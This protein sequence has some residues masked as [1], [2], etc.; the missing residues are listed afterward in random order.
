MK[1]EIYGVKHNDELVYVG[2]TQYGMPKRRSKHKYEAYEELYSDPFHVFIR[3]FS[4]IAI[5]ISQTSQCN[6][7][8]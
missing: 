7:V 6:K 5:Y 8:R 2:K 4:S 3:N 1:Y